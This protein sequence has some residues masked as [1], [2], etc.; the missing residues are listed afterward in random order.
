MKIH[1]P[2]ESVNSGFNEKTN[3]LRYYLSDVE[4][5]NI[6]SKITCKNCLKQINKMK[7]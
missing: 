6:I 1:Y 3:C 7:D 5:T 4:G 2:Q